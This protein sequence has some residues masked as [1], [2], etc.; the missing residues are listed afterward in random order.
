MH[1]FERLERDSAGKC[2]VPQSAREYAFE[3][4]DMKA[5]RWN[6]RE[7][8]NGL[9]TAVALAET[10]AVENGVET[11]TLTDKHLRAVVKMSSG[12]RD[13]LRNRTLAVQHV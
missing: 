8:R 5:L 12:F 2:Y 4:A 10:E 9:Q 1:N 11:V 3:A 6:G 7:I 13:F